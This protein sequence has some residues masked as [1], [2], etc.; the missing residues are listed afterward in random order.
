MI[1]RLTPRGLQLERKQQL[2][3]CTCWRTKPQTRAAKGL[4]IVSLAITGCWP[5]TVASMNNIAALQPPP[6]N[7]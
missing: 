7:I 3:P 1:Q 2:V 4:G 5:N 6:T